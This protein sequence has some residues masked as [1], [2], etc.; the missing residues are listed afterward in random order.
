MTSLDWKITNNGER[1]TVTLVSRTTFEERWHPPSVTPLDYAL[2]SQRPMKGSRDQACSWLCVWNV[3]FSLL[4]GGL[5]CVPQSRHTNR[6][7]AY[8]Q[9]YWKRNQVGHSADFFNPHTPLD[10]TKTKSWLS[11]WLMASSPLAYPY[12]PTRNT[13][14]AGSYSHSQPLNPHDHNF[15]NGMNLSGPREMISTF[16]SQNQ[17]TL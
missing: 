5:H 14:C 8:Q 1:G 12:C 10:R 17:E 3:S 11:S 15:P 16:C 7:S 9:G 13:D 2:C 4:S 6:G